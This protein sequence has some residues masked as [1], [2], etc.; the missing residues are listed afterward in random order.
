MTLNK[1]TGKGGSMTLSRK[2][3]VIIWVFVLI[4]VLLLGLNRG[5]RYLTGRINGY[6]YD[7]ITFYGIRMATDYQGEEIYEFLSG[8]EDQ[9]FLLIGIF[10]LI[11]TTLIITSKKK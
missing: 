5:S 6:Q 4:A 2:Q 7:T 9:K 10:A 8:V 1:E 11:S 3:K